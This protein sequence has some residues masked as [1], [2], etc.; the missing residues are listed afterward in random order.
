MLPLPAGG[1]CWIRVAPLHRLLR[2]CILCEYSNF[3][4]TVVQSAD[5]SKQSTKCQDKAWSRGHRSTCKAWS[6]IRKSAAALSGNPK[7]WA[8]LTGFLE[9]HQDSFVNATLNAYL[10]Q[11]PEEMFPDVAAD[12]YTTFSLWY[13]NDPDLPVGKKFE[14]RNSAY[15][16]SVYPQEPP[17]VLKSAAEGY[18]A[19]VELGKRQ[20]GDSYQGTGTYVLHILFGAEDRTFRPGQTIPFFLS[21]HFSIEDRQAVADVACRDPFQQLKENVDEGKKIRFCCGVVPGLSQCCCGGWTHDQLEVSQ[22]HGS[23]MNSV[24][25]RSLARSRVRTSSNIFTASLVAIT[26]DHSYMCTPNA[27]P[28]IANAGLETRR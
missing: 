21:K 26:A 20:F 9:Y 1:A 6:P 23:K 7:A 16:S 12:N 2:G 4:E 13:R 19:A 24:D 5:V 15:S 3:M 8:D 11:I 18:D 28:V 17:V 22:V 27:R 14:L 10:S 25:R